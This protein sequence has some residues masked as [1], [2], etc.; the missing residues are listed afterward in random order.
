MEAGKNTLIDRLYGGLIENPERT[1]LWT[2]SMEALEKA[3]MGSC[4]PQI[5]A[6]GSSVPGPIRSREWS[7]V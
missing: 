1:P 3:V 6:A 7:W 2:A 5:L 4:E